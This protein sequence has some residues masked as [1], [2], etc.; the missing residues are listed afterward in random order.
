MIGTDDSKKQLVRKGNNNKMDAVVTAGTTPFDI[1]YLL[2]LQDF[3]NSISARIRP[4]HIFPACSC[5]GDTVLCNAASCWG[6]RRSTRAA[7]RIP[8]TRCHS[9][10]V[11]CLPVERPFV[12]TTSVCQYKISSIDLKTRGFGPGTRSGGKEIKQWSYM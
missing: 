7:M 6:S 4:A 9:G 8:N 2:F 1:R 10:E 5:T 12:L 3:R 11:R